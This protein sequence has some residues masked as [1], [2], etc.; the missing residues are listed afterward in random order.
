M[1]NPLVTVIMPTYKRSE[2]LDRA[3]E[4]VIKQTYKNIE[5]IIVD[6]NNPDSEWRNKTENRVK[7]YSHDNRIRYICHPRNMNGS[8][9]RNTGIESANGEIITFLDDDD[10]YRE[11]KI[12]KQVDYLIKHPEFRAVYCG[13]NRIETF[14]PK[15]EG[16]LSFEILSSR[17]IIITNTIMMWR[18]DAI[19]CGGFDPTFKRHQEA[20]LLLNYFRNAGKIG[21]ISD[22]LV[23]F[24]ISDRSN[25]PSNSD[26]FEEYTIHMLNSYMDLI[27]K[28]EQKRHGAKRDIYSWR[29]IGILLGH[30]QA[31]NYKS[32]LR[33]YKKMVKEMPFKFN[34]DLLCY[35]SK[36]IGR[37]IYGCKIAES[38]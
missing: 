17:N 32:A 14:R 21:V 30:L 15:L 28:W 29:Y 31:Q 12:E 25:S 11:S 22:V 9:A 8:V 35:I 6:D 1:N 4:S 16:D 37:K 5:L 20:S 19:N 13:W 3:V 2:M 10:W 34:F 7:K 18:E 26:L 23:D 33:V 27:E 24:D 36:W 38:N